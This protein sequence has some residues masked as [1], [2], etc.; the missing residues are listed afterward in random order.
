MSSVDALMIR[1]SSGLVEP[2]AT[3]YGI[4][5]T[6]SEA[7][8]DADFLFALYASVRGPELAAM[9]V[10]DAM[11][12]RLLRMQFD[13]MTRS[14]RA[15]FPTARYEVIVLNDAPIGRLI[16]DIEPVRAHIIYIALL[17]EW[18]NRRIAEALMM[19]VLDVPRRLGAVCEATV[20]HDNAASL[21]LWSKLGFEE[22]ERAAMD[23]VMEWRP[24]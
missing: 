10:D 22:R 14:Y 17:P 13:A 24:R 19:S 20:A 4:L 2:V 21:R 12:K 8:A 6:R 18:R 3:S 1:T 9:P 7:A 5:R 15:T 16:V 23:V 11:R